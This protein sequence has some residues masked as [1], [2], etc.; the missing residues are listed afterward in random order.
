MKHSIYILVLSILVISCNQSKTENPNG[1]YYGTLPCADCPG[2]NY[3]ITFETD[4]TYLETKFYQ[5]RNVDPLKSSGSFTVSQKGIITLT[6]KEDTEEMRQFILKNDTLQMLDISGKPIQ[7]DLSEMYL[8]SNKK[9]ENFIMKAKEKNKAIGFKAT[10][11]EPFWDL[12]IDFVNK[13]MKFKTMEGDSILAPLSKPVKPQDIDAVSYRAQTESGALNVMIIRDECNDSMS[14]KKS[15]HKVRV[16]VQMGDGEMK[17]YNG[18]G[19][20]K[21]DYRLHNLWVLESLDGKQMDS[22][23]KAPN[24]EFN[25]VENK[26]Y[27]FGGCNRINST[28]ETIN[29]SIEIGTVVSTKMACPNLDTEKL[30]LDAISEKTHNFS[31]SGGKLILK[32]DSNTLIFKNVD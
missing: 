24:L 30:F 17:D 20:Y 7:G 6:N 26:M 1:T 31:F 18:C 2:I 13:I 22:K 19:D 14:G 5:E 28:I 32:N 10:G 23:T 15:G 21:G 16:S 29:D 12:E 8:L 9:P 11:N 3:K 4:S 27:G 25:L